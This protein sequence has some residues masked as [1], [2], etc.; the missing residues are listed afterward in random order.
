MA[1]RAAHA[2]SALLVALHR[3]GARG[4]SGDVE[5]ALTELV[6][7][8][9]PLCPAV[10]LKATSLGVARGS[11]SWRGGGGRGRANGGGRGCGVK[12]GAATGALRTLLKNELI[13]VRRDGNPAAARRAPPGGAR[14]LTPR[15][16][17]G[18]CCMLS[19]RCSSCW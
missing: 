11:G 8:A 7:A 12:P 17:G 13:S 18:G 3:A 19:S 2:C 4:R 16:Y 5:M 15:R 6:T 1:H 14:R 10:S 9:Q